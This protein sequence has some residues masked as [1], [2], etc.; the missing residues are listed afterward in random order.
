MAFSRSI[1]NR[2][3]IMARR[4]QPLFAYVLHEDDRKNQPSNEFQS[5]QKPGDFVQQRY[6][7]TG[8]SNSSSGFG[9]LFQDRKCSQLAFLPSSGMSF[10][11]LMSTTGSDKPDKFELI[12]DVADVLKDTAVE[13]VAS[14]APAVNEVAV[15]AADCWLP[16]ASLQYVIDSI[17]SFTGLNCYDV[18]MDEEE[19]LM[20]L[21]RPRL[22]EIRERMASKDGD[23]PSMVEGQN[24]MKKLFKE[25]GVTPFTPLKGLFIQGPIFISFY[26]AI[27]TMTEK[28]PSFKCGGACWFTDLTTPDSLYLF[29]VLTAL[30][31]F[32][33]VEASCNMQEGMEGNPAAATMRNVSRVLAVLTVPFTMNF[34]K[35]LLFLKIFRYVYIS[36]TSKPLSLAVLKAPRVKKAL[37]IP[38]IPDQPAATAS[39]PSIDLYSALK[40]TLQQARTAAEESASVSAAPTKVLNRSTPSSAVNQ[41]IKHLEKQAPLFGAIG[42]K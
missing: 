23:S 6:F 27:T 29:P 20:H 5:H 25:Y 13:A 34:P 10:Y 41:R 17:H 38:E 4:Y 2:V 32:I 26:L 1:C 3:T 9:V 35:D 18:D 21:M 28:M 33:T 16:V 8:F 31:F 24:E 7:G 36:V 30:T 37:G 11:R 19:E 12:G 14:Q 22:E 42:T 15:A 40:Q 39:R